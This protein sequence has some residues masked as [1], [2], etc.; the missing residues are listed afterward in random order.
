MSNYTTSL[1][2]VQAA[3]QLY[4]ALPA[5]ETERDDAVF[6]ARESAWWKYVNLRNRYLKE[7]GMYKESY[8]PQ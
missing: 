7:R 1:K 5:P 2:E 4:S 6:E 3:W 8:V